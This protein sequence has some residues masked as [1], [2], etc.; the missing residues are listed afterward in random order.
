[1]HQDEG[2]Y[3]GK[4][5]DGTV[6]NETAASAVRSLIKNE[7]ISC[8]AAHEAAEETGLEPLVIGQTIDLLEARINGCQLGLFGR[9]LDRGRAVSET[10]NPSAELRAEVLKSAEDGKIS[11]LELWKAAEKT[12]SSKISAAAVCEDEGL[13]IYKC[14]LG[15]F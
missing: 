6:L 4:H 10:V 5:P 13:K 11:C 9:K 7:R 15:A 2:N 3:S 1:M 8:R 12:G 14:Q